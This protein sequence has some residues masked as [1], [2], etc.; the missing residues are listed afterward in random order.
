[1]VIQPGQIEMVI[2][3]GQSPDCNANYLGLY[4]SLD[5]KFRATR[6]YD[7]DGLHSCVENIFR[8]YPAETL[9]SIFDATMGVMRKINA[10]DGDNVY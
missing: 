4:N 1:M 5:S 2:Q 6:P 3:P 9:N 7:T 8:A 10:S